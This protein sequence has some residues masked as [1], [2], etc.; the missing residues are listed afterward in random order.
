MFCIYFWTI[1]CLIF[2]KSLILDT[3]IHWRFFTWDNMMIWRSFVLIRKMLWM[4]R[5]RFKTFFIFLMYLKT[6]IHKLAT[7]YDS[8]IVLFVAFAIFDVFVATI[9]SVQFFAYF[10]VFAQIL[11]V[12]FLWLWGVGTRLFTYIAVLKNTQVIANCTVVPNFTMPTPFFQPRLQ[13]C[14]VFLWSLPSSMYFS[15]NLYGR[16]SWRFRE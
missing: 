11:L 10:F 3:L 13:T 4:F 12:L 2:I 6:S 7:I 1:Y 16:L 9:Y 15:H 5:A 14:I 8:R